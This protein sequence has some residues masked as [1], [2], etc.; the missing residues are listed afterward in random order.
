MSFI[1]S[2]IKIH[3]VYLS[4]LE[5]ALL[6]VFLAV[7]NLC[8]DKETG[9]IVTH[10]SWDDYEDIRGEHLL[11]EGDQDIFVV[12]KQLTQLHSL[13]ESISNSLE[14]VGYV[15]YAD[16]TT[17]WSIDSENNRINHQVSNVII[18]VVIVKEF[19]YNHVAHANVRT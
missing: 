19:H 8:Y 11:T 5:D 18:I 13:E 10:N 15:K 3:V 12:K 2:Q 4:F 7:K 9:I 17:Y 14:F 6:T 16:R 1:F